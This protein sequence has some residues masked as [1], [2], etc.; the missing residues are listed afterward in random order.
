V[1]I[2]LKKKHY[3]LFFLKNAKIAQKTK[4]LILFTSQIKIDEIKAFHVDVDGF[5]QKFKFFNF[6]I[7]IFLEDFLVYL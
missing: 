3:L 1:I 4:F 6:K 5:Q 2:E 7:N